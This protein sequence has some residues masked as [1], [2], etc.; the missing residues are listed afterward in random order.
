MNNRNLVF[1]HIPKTAGTTLNSILERHYPKRNTFSFWQNVDQI[2][3]EFP[4]W[5]IERRRQI[6]LL[7]GHMP[8]GLHRFLVGESRYITVLRA[9]VE[10]IV[11]HY[12]FVK[13]TPRHYLYQQVIER[14]LSLAEYA[15]SG[16]TEELDNGQVRLLAG[17]DRSIPYGSCGREHLELAKR[18]VE[19]HFAVVGLSERFEESLALMGIELGWNWIPY[20]QAMN[21]TEGRPKERQIDPSILKSIER[22]NQFDLELYAWVAKR[23]EEKLDLHRDEVLLRLARLARAN[24]IYRPLHALRDHV[25]KV[26]RGALF[27]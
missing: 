3:R 7:K 15:S 22:D 14:N 24:K 11:S 16:I 5:P 13:R 2:V 10:R 26:A 18:N 27:K 20:Y 1:I 25:R 4:E 8:F 19:E 6:R 12:F 21:I 9:P 17:I 23:F